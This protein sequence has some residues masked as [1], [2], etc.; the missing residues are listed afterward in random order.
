[1]CRVRVQECFGVLEIPSIYAIKG[2]LVC[3][4]NPNF[5]YLEVF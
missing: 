4:D 5:V 2:F 1:M 3:P